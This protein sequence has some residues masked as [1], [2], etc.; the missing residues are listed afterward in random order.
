[1]TERLLLCLT[2]AALVVMAALSMYPAGQE[3]TYTVFPVSGGV[4]AESAADAEAGAARGIDL[5]R[6]DAETLC[7]LPG[8]GA[9][10]AQRIVDWR[11]AHG[12]FHTVEELLEING[13]GPATVAGLRDYVYI[14]EETE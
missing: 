14:T 2:A 12:A 10:L 9:V 6:A 8:I 4:S 7:D 5:N 3:G 11:E 13:I 1:M